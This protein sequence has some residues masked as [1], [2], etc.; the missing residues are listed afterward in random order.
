[1]VK[2]YDCSNSV[3]RPH[4]RGGGGPVNNDV[5]RYL[6]ENADAYGCQYVQSPNL[7]DVIVTN[8]KRQ[9]FPKDTA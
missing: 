9:R 7:A 2:I 4:H 8:D 1:M 5:M 6:M 3:H